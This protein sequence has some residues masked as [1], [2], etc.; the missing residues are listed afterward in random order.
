MNQTRALVLG[1]AASIHKKLVEQFDFIYTIA[2][3]EGVDLSWND[4]HNLR[5]TMK[6]PTYAILNDGVFEKI[7]TQYQRFSDINS[8]R[9]VAVN[10]RESEIYNGFVVTY[11]KIRKIIDENSINL[12]LFSNFP[13]EGFDYIIYLVARFLGIKTIATHQ[14]LIPG[15]FWLSSCIEEFGNFSKSPVIEA[16]VKSNYELPRQWFYM[17][18]S[19]DKW[20]YTETSLLR[21]VAAR[22]WRLPVAAIRYYYN[23][24]YIKDRE[25]SIEQYDE[26]AR[27]IYVPL[28]MQP[29]LTS[30][31]MGGYCGRYADQLQMIE[32]L[33]LIVPKD[34]LI[35]VKENPKQ[36]V[37]QRGGLFYRRLAVLPNVKCVDPR[38][39]SECLIKNSIGVATVTGTAGWEGLFYGK[40]C[41]VF[42]NA[43]YSEFTGVTP[44][45]R[46]ITFEAWMANRPSD[47]EKLVN[48]LDNLLTKTGVGVVD[49]AHAVVVPGFDEYSNAESVVNSIVKYINVCREERG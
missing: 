28:H 30:S 20:I 41:M 45:K 37:Q 48:E 42:G 23:R 16:S 35:Y 2:D 5:F 6:P 19:D 33:S 10:E 13:H 3:G 18:D 49:P 24:M 32:Q 9:Y 36:T 15:R 39:S 38:I 25:N 43:W 29:E 26:N 21:E 1:Y 34:Y 46:D 47:K 40:P 44:F 11:Y 12:V 14:C 8:R 4:L 7:L 17:S 27:Y 31:A 22:P